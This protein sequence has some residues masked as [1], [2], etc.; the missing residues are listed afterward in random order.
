MI[1]DSERV[2]V[3]ILWH[4]GTR[5]R[6]EVRRPVRDAGQLSYCGELCARVRALKEEGLGHAGIA[7]VLNEEGLQPPRK[8]LFNKGMV[9]SLV[10][11]IGAGRRARKRGR[12]MPAARRPDEWTM[13][14]L[15][16][17]TGV[18]KSTLYKW[19]HDGRISARKA[20]GRG[21]SGPRLW[22]IRA[23]GDTFDSIRKWRE[24]PGS[25]KEGR[26]MPD[27]KTASAVNPQTL[28]G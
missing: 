21:G 25:E 14:E 27:F 10:D 7:E 2:E 28:Y 15:A 24:T 19:I 12:S 13:A 5:T 11:R 22:L 9:A 18:C 17:R 1:D 16:E 4:G 3:E 23:D 20:A 8:S 26:P 6:A